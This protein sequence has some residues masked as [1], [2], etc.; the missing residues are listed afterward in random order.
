MITRWEQLPPWKWTF[1][2]R[3]QYAAMGFVFSREPL[4]A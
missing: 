2:T 3:R 1:D 4:S